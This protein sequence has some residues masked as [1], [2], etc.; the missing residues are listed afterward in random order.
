MKLGSAGMRL[1][2]ESSSVLPGL[3]PNL[4]VEKELEDN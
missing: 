3:F 1:R 2:F 4:G